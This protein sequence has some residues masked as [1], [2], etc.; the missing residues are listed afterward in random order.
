MYQMQY[1]QILTSVF[2]RYAHRLERR[3]TNMKTTKHSV[4]K[5][6]CLTSDWSSHMATFWDL[7]EYFRNPWDIG[8]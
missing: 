5:H 8:Q 6:P 7:G 4:T 2:R 3:K 1:S